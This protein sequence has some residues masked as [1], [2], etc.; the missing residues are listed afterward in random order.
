MTGTLTQN[1]K[2]KGKTAADINDL[3]PSVN[4]FLSYNSYMKKHN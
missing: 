4:K 3:I 1:K 2:I